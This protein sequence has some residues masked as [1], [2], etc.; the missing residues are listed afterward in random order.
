MTIVHS[1]TLNI[2]AAAL[3]ICTIKKHKKA[4]EK[5]SVKALDIA[6]VAMNEYSKV[7]TN[8]RKLRIAIYCTVQFVRMS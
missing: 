5:I 3:R 4:T 6:T 2:V 1:A 7:R 8:A